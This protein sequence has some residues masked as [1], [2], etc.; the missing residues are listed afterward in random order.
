MARTPTFGS[1]LT[2]P[3][4]QV[5]VKT[6]TTNNYRD[7]WIMSYTPSLVVGGWIGNNDNSSMER[8]GGIP[9]A[10]GMWRK[11]MSEA[12]ATVPEEVFNA[13]EET[14]TLA[15]KPIL[16][17]V[18]QGGDNYFIDTISGKLATEYTPQE[19]KKEIITTDVHDILYWINKKDPRGPK[20]E[21]P[22]ND[23]QFLRWETT[24]RDW[25]GTH[26]NEYGFIGGGL[27]PTEY[28]DIHT[29]DKKP[30]VTIIS[31]ES[32][33]VFSKNNPLTVSISTSGQYSI[34][35]MEVFINGV[36]IGKT[37]G[38]PFIY[39]FTPSD[40][41]EIG[42]TNEIQI[43]VYDTVYNTGEATARFGIQ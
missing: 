16:R 38:V 7:A 24:V 11:I 25:W 31:P 19:T 35:K 6:G 15:D 36:F 1:S 43:I 41:P 23:P 8:I 37:I 26:G 28:D 18:W 9:S 39:S 14:T 22:Y 32:G 4:R 3:G 42:E 33:A 2:I 30:A 13:P 40:I 17:G 20:P 10:S 21:N 29:P 27:K 12:L 5:A 34:K